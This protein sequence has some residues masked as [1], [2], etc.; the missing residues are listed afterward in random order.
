[1][2]HATW[3][4]WTD[5]W[6]RRRRHT[7]KSKS[8]RWSFFTHNTRPCTEVT[9]AAS[10]SK[11]ATNVEQQNSAAAVAA[12]AAT[13]VAEDSPIMSNNSQ[14]LPTTERVIKSEWGFRVVIAVGRFLYCKIVYFECIPVPLSVVVRGYRNERTNELHTFPDVVRLVFRSLSLTLSIS[15]LTISFCAFCTSFFR[16]VS[17]FSLFSSTSAVFAAASSRS[18]TFGRMCHQRRALRVFRDAHVLYV[19]A[20]YCRR[21]LITYYYYYYYS[22]YY[23]L[24][25]IR[26]QFFW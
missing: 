18:R 24:S 20:A 16:G 14:K 3:R 4:L 8:R 9:T 17:I 19:T 11:T 6:R 15:L 25:S 5:A 2:V 26:T 1:M 23:Y 7:A 10:G 13:A 12:A 21:V 22:C